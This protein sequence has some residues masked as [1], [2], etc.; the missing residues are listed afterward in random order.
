VYILKVSLLFAIV[1]GALPAKRHPASS[2]VTPETPKMASGATVQTKPPTTTDSR[3]SVKKATEKKDDLKKPLAKKDASKSDG[4][5]I[6]SSCGS[7]DNGLGA[8]WVEFCLICVIG[9]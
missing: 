5:L 8:S 9:L 6:L 3:S 1:L 4:S 7:V 2:K